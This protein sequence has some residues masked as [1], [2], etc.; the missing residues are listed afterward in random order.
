MSKTVDKAEVDWAIETLRMRGRPR[1]SRAVAH[2]IL[3]SHYE[4]IVSGV[5]RRVVS[6]S[7][8]AGVH[9]LRLEEEKP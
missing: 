5:V 1:V 7:V 9:E 3:K 4:I 2:E 8:G 6:K